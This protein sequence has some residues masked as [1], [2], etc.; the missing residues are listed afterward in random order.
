MEPVGVAIAAIGKRT[1]LPRNFYHREVGG[2]GCGPLAPVI[3]SSL[4]SAR[5]AAHGHHLGLIEELDGTAVLI[6]VDFND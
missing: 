6:L 5:H 2:A 4:F 1:S 3:D